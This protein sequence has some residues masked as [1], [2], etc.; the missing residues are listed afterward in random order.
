ME[1]ALPGDLTRLCDRLA[2]LA[3]TPRQR[4]RAYEARLHL[5]YEQSDWAALRQLSE[6]TLAHASALGDTNLLLICHDA[7]A[8]LAIFEGHHDDAAS[9]L[10][11]LDE[12]SVTLDRPLLRA[13]TRYGQG[14]VMG[15]TDPRSAVELLEAS[16]T[17]SEHA[18][19]HPLGR[20]PTLAKLTEVWREHGHAPNAY[21]VSLRVRE[22][23]ERSDVAS[24]LRLVGAHALFLAQLLTGEYDAALGTLRGALK[25]D[26]PPQVWW[27][28]VLRLDLAELL[29]TLG[30]PREALA[31]LDAVDARADLHEVDQPRR[32]LLRARTLVTLGRPADAAF[33]EALA[34][35]FTIRHAYVHARLL[36]ARA[37]TL[38]LARATRPLEEALEIARAANLGG[39]RIEA[40]VA[41][42]QAHLTLGQPELARTHGAQAVALS[43][44]FTSDVPT[45]DVWATHA[46][47]LNATGD[48]GV[49]AARERARLL[50]Q[51][52]ERRVPSGYR[53]T[54]NSTR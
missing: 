13:T 24:H 20:V 27:R 38:P 45:F 54:G 26:V 51:D 25:L 9:H 53:L 33:D 42:A 49:T 1:L 7:L 6:T 15:Y 4:A 22:V 28:S 41:L 11:R 19:G 44:T 31:E 2:R 47:A 18:G 32:L 37:A 40:L 36:I 52:A 46:A 17:L 50:R 10:A 48:P 5:L 43:E 29:L 8:M 23:L 12:F 16:V 30:A 21:G 34:R 35:P 3:R 39:V 14:W